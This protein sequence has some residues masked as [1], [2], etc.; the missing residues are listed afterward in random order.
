MMDWACSMAASRTGASGGCDD[1]AR[2]IAFTVDCAFQQSG[3][4]SFALLGKS[5]RH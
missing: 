3:L 1:Q 5:D 2:P 4:F